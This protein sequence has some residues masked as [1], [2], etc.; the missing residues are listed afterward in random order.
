MAE[1][2]PHMH[3]GTEDASP[4]TQPLP[5]EDAQSPRFHQQSPSTPDQRRTAQPARLSVTTDSEALFRRSSGLSSTHR[6]SRSP[7]PSDGSDDQ[8]DMMQVAQIVGVAQDEEEADASADGNGNDLN[9]GLLP[10]GA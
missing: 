3:A 9:P 7:P 8:D 6:Q 2:T 1:T 10:D 5:L 4:V